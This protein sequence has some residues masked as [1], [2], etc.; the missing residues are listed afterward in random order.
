MNARTGT[1]LTCADGEYNGKSGFV[2]TV[3]LPKEIPHYPKTGHPVAIVPLQEWEALQAKIKAV[4]ALEGCW[5]ERAKRG[6]SISAAVAVTQ[7]HN[8]LNPGA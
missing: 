2:A 1:L 4:E 7:L 6:K 3:Y 5:Y 8:A